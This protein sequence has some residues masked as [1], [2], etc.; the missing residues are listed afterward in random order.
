MKKYI[1]LL[2]FAFVLTSCEDVI[3][4]Q[5][6]AADIDLYN[7]EGRITTKSNPWVFVGKAVPVS[8]DEAIPGISDAIVTITDN[9]VPSNQQILVEIEGHKGY[10][11]VPTGTNFLGAIGRTY[12][13]QIIIESDTVTAAEVLTRVEPLDSISVFPSLRGEEQFLGIFTYGLETPGLGNHYKW[14]IYIND[15][16]LYKTENLLYANDELVD[17]SYISGLEVF[18]DFHDLKN[19][20]DRLLNLNDTVQVIQSSIS[21]AAYDFYYQLYAQSTSGGM[22]SVPP[23]NIPGNFTCSNGKDVLGLFTA[24]DISVSNRVIIDENILGKLKRTW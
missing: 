8:V 19:P 5:M 22:F 7:I 15:T 17:G 16:H 4:V 3:E 12:S 6:N 11:S 20:E 18:T 9:A 1:H 24:N 23:A 10:Y 2:L 21:E 14:D 13:L